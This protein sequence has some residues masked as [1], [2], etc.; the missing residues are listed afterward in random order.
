MERQMPGGNFARAVL[1]KFRP[2]QTSLRAPHFVTD[3]ESYVDMLLVKYSRDEAMSR[4]VGG[5]YEETG[6]RERAILEY[7]G[8]RAGMTL[9]DVGC[10]SGRLASAL[11]DMPLDYLGTDV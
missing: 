3:Y 8:L 6:W 7:A 10:G 4:A 1:R 2:P 11:A 9:V 5:D